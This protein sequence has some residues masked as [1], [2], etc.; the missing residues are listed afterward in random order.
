MVLEECILKSVVS[1]VLF[2][3]EMLPFVTVIRNLAKSNVQPDSLTFESLLLLY[4]CSVNSSQTLASSTNRDS[5]NM[6]LNVDTSEIEN[7]VWLKWVW[8]R[9]ILSG[10]RLASMIDR[11]QL[12]TVMF[13][14][15]TALTLAKWAVKHTTISAVD[16]APIIEKDERS[17]ICRELLVV[18]NP[19]WPRRKIM[20]ILLVLK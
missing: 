1:N 7:F 10:P 17:F 4:M 20:V 15:C 19:W 16:P 6:I 5:S 18:L 8:S 9:D 13:S 12:F 11:G 14:M 2:S 3:I